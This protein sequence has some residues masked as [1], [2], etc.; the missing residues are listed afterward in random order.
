MSW[1]IQ[2]GALDALPDSELINSLF[3]MKGDVKGML[4]MPN[5]LLDFLISIKSVLS[6]KVMR[7]MNIL[8]V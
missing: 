4:P 8:I 6:V 3:S 2:E 5:K 7:N 1:K